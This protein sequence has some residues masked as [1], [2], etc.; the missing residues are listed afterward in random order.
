MRYPVT[1]SRAISYCGRFCWVFAF[2][3][4]SF[5]VNG[6]FADTTRTLHEIAPGITLSQEITTGDHPLI[7]H[8]LHIDL[9]SKTIHVRSGQALD[10]ITLNGPSKGREPLHLLAN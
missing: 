6:S 1:A 4:L 3:L 2:T 7:I 5:S 8:C 10:A 9:K